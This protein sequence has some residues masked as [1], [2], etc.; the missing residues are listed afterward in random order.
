MAWVRSSPS[1][2]ET[3]NF[4]DPNRVIVLPMKIHFPKINR[5]V[6]SSMSL[7]FGM[8]V[9]MA[10]QAKANPQQVNW[11]SPSKDHNG[12]MP[13]GNGDIGANV[14]VEPNGDLCFH[15]SKTDAWSEN[16][17]LLKLGKLRL[18][19]EPA[20]VQEGVAFLQTL[21]TETGTITI[22]T[23]DGE[24]TQIRIWVDANHPVMQVEV[25]AEQAHAATLSFEPWRT[26]RRQLTAGRESSSAR[27]LT[28]NGA[29]PIFVEPDKVL[30]DQSNRIVW[31]HRNERS[32]WKA[33]L[34]LQALVDYA[35]PEKDP[36]LHRTFGALV[37]GAGLVSKDSK[38][39][40]TEKASKRLT[41]A[42]HPLT[43]QTSTPDAWMVQ[44]EKQ[45]R[46]I[47][48]LKLAARYAQHK[49]WWQAFWD[50]S[51]I[52]IG[53][54]REAEDVTRAYVLQ[55]F[56]HAAGGR[57]NSPIKFNGSIFT[58][59]GESLGNWDADFRLWGGNYWWQNTRLPYWSML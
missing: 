2:S 40:V 15:L 44:V 58:V 45:A 16:G 31:Y 47:G 55:R 19:L 53:G 43:A 13:I 14:W 38:T 17:R 1:R 54:D 5:I 59:E 30:S 25:D 20:L 3:T 35:D 32:V 39:L 52:V 7:L 33:N 9:A 24:Q 21:D 4:P 48:K 22:G 23:G 46:T 8:L 49:A 51:H 57:G 11:N 10:M 56:I 27:A 36:L 42:I 18:R 50:R 6:K 37:E 34:E 26:K 12:S 41:I 29:A 28:G